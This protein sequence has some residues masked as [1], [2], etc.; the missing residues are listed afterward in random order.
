[1]DGND[2]LEN[3]GE[4]VIDLGSGDGCIVILTAKKFEAHTLA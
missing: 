3:L 4:H 1:M 2:F